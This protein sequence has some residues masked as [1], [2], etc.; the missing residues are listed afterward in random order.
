MSLIG[1]KHLVAAPVDTYTKGS[2]ITYGTGF[3]IGPLVAVNLSFNVADNPDFGDDVELD[4]DDGING[5][6]GTMDMNKIPIAVRAKLLNWKTT[7]TTDVTYD[8]RDRMPK[9]HG[10][11]YY[12]VMVNEGV[13]TVEAMWFHM[14]KFTQQSI[15]DNTKKRAIEWGHPQLNV[16][17]I[18]ALLDGSGE[19]SWFIPKEFT[20]A[21][22]EADAAAW[23]DAKAGVPSTPATTT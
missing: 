19:A 9:E 22:A 7:G 15:V 17:G 18:G 21:S 6:N 10:W 20:G 8:V 16:N 12:R 11:G 14:A 3:V 5:Y 23:L 1:C 13:R 2:P 4:N